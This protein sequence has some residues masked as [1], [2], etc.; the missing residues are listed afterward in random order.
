MAK[1]KY[2]AR[3]VL[4]HA[5][6]VAAYAMP[7]VHLA[8]F[9]SLVGLETG[10]LTNE[11]AAGGYQRMAVA[12]GAAADAEDGAQSLNSAAVDFPVATAD[13]GPMVAWALLD[14]ATGGNVLYWGEFPKYG[15]PAAYKAVYA[16][17][18]FRIRIGDLSLSEE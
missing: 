9:S 6:G 8:L 10:V 7:T 13:W 5:L 17:D 1:S 15:D 4:D 16:G 18:S 12:F 3:K 11:I 2:L 14:A